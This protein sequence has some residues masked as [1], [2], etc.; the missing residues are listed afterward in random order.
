MDFATALVDYYTKALDVSMYLTY[1]ILTAG[2]LIF[3][4]PSKFDK[5]TIIIT[6]VKALVVYACFIVFE[7]LAF[8]MTMVIGRYGM[9]IFSLSFAVIPLIYISIFVKEPLLQK[10]IKQEIV[11][12]S[13][14]TLS[15]LIG[16]LVEIVDIVSNNNVFANISCRVIPLLTLI[17]ISVM[18]KKYNIGRYKTMPKSN[19]VLV[20]LASAVLVFTSLW[21]VNISTDDMSIKWLLILNNAGALFILVYMYYAMHASMENRHK[22]TALEVQSSI[23]QLEK[24]S[25]NIDQ[26]NREELMKIRHDLNNQLSYIK[27]LLDE[28]KYDDAK[29]YLNGLLQ[30]KEEFLESFSC[31]NTVISGIVNLE[32]TKAKIAGKKIKFRAVVPPRLP[33]E[34]SD[35]LSLITNIADNCIENFVPENDI[36][37]ITISIVT[38][39]DYLRIVSFNTVSGEMVNKQFSLSTTKDD[40]DHGYGTKIIKNIAEK[41]HGYSTFSIDGKKF[42]CD[43]V[44]DMSY[45]SDANNG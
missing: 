36:D 5:K 21:E 25:L 43:V 11:V 6:I 27:V 12:A 23:L 4:W 1:A 14:L 39:Q 2:L 24:D 30:Q 16:F 15:E 44:L 7:S 20:S 13:I 29:Q 19:I 45:R 8:A 28:Q 31:P 41:Y 37:K 18:L 33:F 10:I 38:Q 26:T 17:F 42:V 22:I 3:D 40:K 9:V 34:D 35:L 32:L